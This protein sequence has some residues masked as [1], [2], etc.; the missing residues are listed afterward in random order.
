V[1]GGYLLPIALLKEA[2]RMQNLQFDDGY[3]E[4]SINGDE[5]RVIR[6]N[7]RDFAILERIKESYDAIEAASATS[8]D[9]ELKPDGS[10][11]NELSVAAGIVRKFDD[12]VKEAINHIFNSDVSTAVFGKQSPLS[13]VGGSPLYE[14]FLET[15][16]PVIRKEVEAESKKSRDRINKY[17]SQVK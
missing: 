15:V 9:T 1:G 10:P 11:L 8:E 14:R 4:F 2:R 17:T 6:F 7:P 3:K 12:T 13:L 16:I 5:S